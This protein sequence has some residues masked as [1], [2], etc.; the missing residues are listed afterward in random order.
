MIYDSILDGN[1]KSSL[2]EVCIILHKKEGFEDFENSLILICNYI[3]Y[4]IN[5]NY[6]FKW[7][8]II[9]STYSF[10]SNEKV[11]IDDTL[12][13]VTKM[14]ILCKNIQEQKLLSIHQL[15]KRLLPFFKEPLSSLDI[16]H[17]ETI[18]PSIESESYNIASK[19]ANCFKNLFIELRNCSNENLPYTVNNLRLCI[20]FVCRRNIYIDTTL[21]KDH[22]CIWFLWGLL[23]LISNNSQY[24][25]DTYNLFIYNWKSSSRKKRL[26]I[27]YSSIFLAII[28]FRMELAFRWKSEDERLFV[29]IQNVSKNMMETVRQ[30]FPIEKKTE[31]NTNN[32]DF[33]LT[34]IPTIKN[35]PT[36]SHQNT[37]DIDQKKEIF[38]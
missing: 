9:H 15:R 27:L 7:Y 26:G 5:I 28:S 29:H 8:D 10:L 12:I 4:N 3:G 36:S 6:A 21:H 35:V 30:K 11:I 23:T 1:V 13:L 22:D 2:E 18:L 19:I 17:F 20:E 37:F 14:C 25:Q 38:Y 31:K 16:V 33:I 24:I 32:I 34:Y